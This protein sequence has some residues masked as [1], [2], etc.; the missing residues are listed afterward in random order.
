LAY[1]PKVLLYCGL[2]ERDSVCV[3][4]YVYVFNPRLLENIGL[5]KIYLSL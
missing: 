3:C 4:V 1:S 2:K 5:V